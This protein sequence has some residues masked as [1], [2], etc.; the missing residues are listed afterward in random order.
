MLGI[1]HGRKSM[2]ENVRAR[3]ARTTSALLLTLAFA[4]LYAFAYAGAAEAESRIRAGDCAVYKTTVQDNIAQTL[5]QHSFFAGINNAEGETGFDIKARNQ[6]S[7]N[8][9]ESHWGTSSGWYPR[10]ED[11]VSG[12]STIYYRD[13]GGYRV[14]PIPTDL[15]ILSK[16]VVFASQGSSDK[17]TVHFGNCLAVDSVGRPVLDSKDHMAHVEDKDA[18]ACDSSHPYRIPRTS[19]LIDWPR[20]FRPATMVSMGTGE[21]MPAGEM[22]HAD[23][24]SALQDEFNAATDQNG[25]GDK[26]DRV[27]KALIDL[28]LN[29]VAQSTQVAHPR[30]GPEPNP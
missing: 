2:P 12:E 10:A 4:L 3:A 21:W 7:C 26:T 1:P 30:C 20:A 19:F 9:P 13:P 28:C 16:K 18:Q 23:Y 15:R 11:F 25:D 24:L 14:R 29:D 8:S 22:F 6:T 5:H 27:D 17:T